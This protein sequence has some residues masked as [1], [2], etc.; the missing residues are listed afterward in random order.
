[1]L[2]FADMVRYCHNMV[3]PDNLAATPPRPEPPLLERARRIGWALL[4]LSVAAMLVARVGPEEWRMAG[5]GTSIA[6]GLF[7]LLAIVNVALVRGL[8]KQVGEMAQ[9]QDDAP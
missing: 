7:G 3:Q 5:I 4:A 6:C 8:Y 2:E 1:M 9:R